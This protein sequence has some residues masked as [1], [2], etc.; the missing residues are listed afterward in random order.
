MSRPPKVQ[1]L[2]YFEKNKIE[3]CVIFWYFKHYFIK[4][5]INSAGVY[6]IHFNRLG[7]SEHGNTNYVNVL[8]SLNVFFT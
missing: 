8:Y 3:M 7:C 6:L 4:K 1:L 5:N 2:N